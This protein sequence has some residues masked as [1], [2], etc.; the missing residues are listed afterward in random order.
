MHQSGQP[1]H[2]LRRELLASLLL[3]A[4][5]V[6][7]A[8]A[9]L[10][11]PPIITPPTQQHLVGKVIFQELVTPNLTRAKQFY[12]SLLGW[13]FRDLVADELAYT[14]V[15]LG[16]RAIGGLFQRDIPANEHRQ[17]AW[18]AYFAA[19]DADAAVELA[20]QHGGKLLFAPRSFPNRGREAVLADPQGAVFAVLASSSGDPSDLLAEQGEWIWS[21]LITHDP[22][23]AAGFYQTIFD[24]EVFPAPA[25][26]GPEHLVLASQGY[27]RAS[28]NSPPAAQPDFH[29]H[30]L[31]YV[32]VDDAASVATRVASLGGRILV[33]PRP[34]PRGGTIALAADP[35][36][37]PFGLLQWS[38][39]DDSATGAQ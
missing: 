5:T 38:T 25:S 34:T 1:H 10:Q 6:P 39:A 2:L 7:A 18:L 27:A 4:C 32:R 31:N 15:M 33:A 24:Y 26:A 11:L 37:A 23:T 3:G 30:W 20:L 9:R 17:S 13:T 29:P 12:G 16:D 28:V 36:G 8:A 22:D 35:L 19:L 21:S 14:E